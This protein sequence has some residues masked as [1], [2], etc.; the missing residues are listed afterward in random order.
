MNKMTK[1][2]FALML[3][4]G[5]CFSQNA[6]KETLK[7]VEIAGTQLQHVFSKIVNQ[8]YDL[9]VSLP[10]GYKDSTKTFP[11]LYLVDGQWDFT[12]GYTI[13]G[14]QFYDGFVPEMIIVGITWGGDKPNYDQ[15]RARD[16]TP[17]QTMQ[18]QTGNAT[19]FLESIR[20]EIIPFVESQ[21]RVNKDRGLWG[22]SYGGLFTIYAMLTETDL[23]NRYFLTSPSLSYDNQLLF[24]LEEKYY[25][26]HKEL[27]ARV[28]MAMG[29]LEGTSLFKKFCETLK[30]RNYKGLEFDYKIVDGMAHSG[31]K[32][33]GFA[34]GIQF[35]YAKT[36]IK[37]DVSIL[38][39]YEG[40]YEFA[41]G[42]NIKI[43]LE[44]DQLTATPPDNSK[45]QLDAENEKDFYI[46]GSKTSVQFEKDGS[47]KVTGFMFTNNGA[48]NFIKKIN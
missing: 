19:K 16:L 20:K 43:Y 1:L 47:G 15:L 11:V 25:E 13:Y 46:K 27:N 39:Q 7:P 32:A 36:N 10:G 4:A 30:G 44:N 18:Q 21:Y 5:I 2:V 33:E 42:M 41:P 28:Y 23:F 40:T 29:G 45:L 22:S 38:K 48:K 6:G 17:T 3:F 37:V 24:K 35:V 14:Q 26:K 12:L 31:T 34:R 8:E 9:Y